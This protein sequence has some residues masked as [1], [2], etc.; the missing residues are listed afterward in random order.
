MLLPILPRVWRRRSRLFNDVASQTGIT[1]K[2]NSAADGIVL[3]NEAGA[4][5]NLKN[6]TATGGP[7]HFTLAAQNAEAATTPTFG[8]ALAAAAAG[9]TAVSRGTLEFSSDKGYSITGTS[10]AASHCTSGLIVESS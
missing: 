10:A 7:W 9:G 5:I 1:A 3:T 6:T 4:D 2:L 8:A